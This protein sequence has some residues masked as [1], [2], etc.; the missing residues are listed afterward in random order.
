VATLG[1]ARDDLD[2]ELRR[3][4]ELSYAHAVEAGASSR[5]LL[6]ST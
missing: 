6:C 3:T 2:D 1:A 4:K 5:P